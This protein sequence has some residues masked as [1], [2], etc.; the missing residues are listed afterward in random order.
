MIKLDGVVVEQK[1]FGDNTLNLKVDP[2]I[3]FN[4]KT[5]KISWLYENDAELFTIICLASWNIILT[6]IEE[7]LK[8][9]NV[10]IYKYEEILKCIK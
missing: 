4:H 9:R 5:R 2:D 1:H 3:Y 10:I 6:M 7:V 8:D